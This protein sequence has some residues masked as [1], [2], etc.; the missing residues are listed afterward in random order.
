MVAEAK[1]IGPQTYRESFGRYYEDFVVGDV[2]QHRPGRTITQY[3]N[4]QFTLMTM[5]YASVTFR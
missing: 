5:R 4:I 1:K 2:Y 3:D